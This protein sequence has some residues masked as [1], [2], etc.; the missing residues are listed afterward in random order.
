MM[1]ELLKAFD[2][3]DRGLRKIIADLEALLGSLQH[4]DRGWKDSFY[5]QWAI[6][7]DVYADALDRGFQ[8][9]PPDYQ[10]LVDDAVQN[11]RRLVQ[12][13]IEAAGEG[14]DTAEA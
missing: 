11:M 9:L 3:R 14:A 12:Q 6:L 8:Q 4:A 2:Q 1:F 13:R 7:E 10:K 5:E